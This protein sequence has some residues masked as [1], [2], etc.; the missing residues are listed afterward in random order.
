M[1]QE[2]QKLLWAMDFNSLSPVDFEK[3]WNY[4]IGDGSHY[5]LVGWGNN[6]LEYYTKNSIEIKNN[7]VI[8]AVNT[9]GESELDCY[10]G[11]ALWTSGKIHTANKVSFKYGRIEVRAKAPQGVGTWPAI[12][13]LGCNLLTG[14]VWPDCGEIDILE[15]TGKEPTNIQ[16][17]I[18]GPGYFGEAGL[19]KII[20]ADQPLSENF[21]TYSIDWREDNIEWFF[22]GVLYN[23]ICRDQVDAI[24]APWPFNNQFYLILNLA[25]GGWFAG[26][27]DPRLE[28]ATFEIESIKHYSID[29]VGSV[30][31]N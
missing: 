5:G 20:K 1:K 23:S 25:I 27:V 15:T 17:T 4:D 22:D 12:W 26:E 24:G 18:H 11:K 14:I 9:H 21:H 30:H 8:E 3:Y 31:I 16:G 29:G 6:E 19:T 7:L 13:L 2:A 10:Y 28:R